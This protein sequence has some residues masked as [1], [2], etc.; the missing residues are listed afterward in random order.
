MKIIRNIPLSIFILVALM[1]TMTPFMESPASAAKATP[2]VA[3]GGGHSIALKEDGTVWGWGYNGHGQL[4]DGTT[5]D[6]T[7]PVQAKVKDN[8]GK[9]V[10]LSGVTA[11]AAGASSS[12][13]LQSDGTVWTWGYNNFGQL[14][15]GTT[16]TRT[17]PVQLKNLSDVTAI[18]AQYYNFFALKKDGTV[19]SWGWNQYGQLGN[20][21]VDKPNALFAHPTPVQVKNLSDVKAIA[22]GYTHCLAL[23][24]DGTVWGWGGNGLGELGDGT[25]IDQYTP[26]QVL[27]KDDDDKLVPL[28]GVTAITTENHHSLALAEDNTVWAWGYNSFGQIGD[29]TS[30][31]S[32]NRST[33]VLVLGG[34]SGKQYLSGV[35][36]MVTGEEHSLTLDKDG[37]M[38]VWGYNSYGQLGDGTTANKHTPVRGLS[39]VAALGA[40]FWH[41]LALKSD[42]TVWT[43]GRNEYGQ[44]GNGTADGL[45]RVVAHPTPIKVLGGDTEDDYLNLCTPDPVDPRDLTDVIIDLTAGGDHS[46]ALKDGTVLAWGRNNNGQLGDGTKTNRRTS[47]PVLVKGDDDTL[48]P[49][50]GVTH[51]TAGG[52]HSLALK[53]GTVLSW[54]WNSFGQLGDGTKTSRRM[55]VTVKVKGLPL[56]D[57]KALA[58]GSYHSLAL[59]EDGTVWSWGRN[60]NGQLGDGTKT[61]RLTPV[62][63]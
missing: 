37:T 59:K 60:N 10:P 19:W 34:E 6:K 12:S 43:W 46:L 11:I 35:T 29:G 36:A 38:W 56:S 23:K 8:D 47:V 55:P 62:Q 52:D 27:V 22:A 53:D 63:V 14:G 44:L 31:T 32:N 18:A 7:Y 25:K 15:D 33:P 26:V 40:G 48:I 24:K 4:G 13:A 16:T 30:G 2:M 21:T 17:T 5:I 42:C 39:D 58:G 20:G 28:L 49:L 57:I 1:L 50:S 54:G 61:N 3:A 45:A 41:S 51:L 9:L